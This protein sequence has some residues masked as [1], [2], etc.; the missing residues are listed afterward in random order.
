MGQRNLTKKGKKGNSS[1]VV[2]ES[3]TKKV[4]APP[5]QRLPTPPPIAEDEGFVPDTE[6]LVVQPSSRL[7]PLTEDTGE[8]LSRGEKRMVLI[9]IDEEGMK[10]AVQKKRRREVPISN[11]LKEQKFKSSKL[12]ANVNQFETADADVLIVDV[13]W[14]LVQVNHYFLLYLF[15]FLL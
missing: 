11:V 13:G 2:P 8:N 14:S 5:T 12:R 15:L 4:L 1:L 3:V 10:E 7:G 9:E 6:A